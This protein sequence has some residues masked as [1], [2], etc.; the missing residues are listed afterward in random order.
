MI[1]IIAPRHIERVQRI[2]LMSDNMNF[3]VQILK[4]NEKIIKG[5]EIIII[6]SFGILQ[7]YFKCAKSVFIG[8][9]LIK[10]L[11]NDG[12]QNPI[13]AAK[14]GCKI[15][16]GPY[17]YNFKEIYNILNKEKISKKVKNIKDL[18]SNLIKDLKN[19]KKKQNQITKGFNN[20]GKKTLIATMKDINNFI[21]NEI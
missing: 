20:L 2:K 7:E 12:G 8:K 6:N 18:N 17:V 15:Y 9:S 14:L 4:K 10:K 21:S 1:T 13:D 16:H 5:K 11:E 19:I 3:N